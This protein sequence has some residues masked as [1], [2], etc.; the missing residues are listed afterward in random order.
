MMQNCIGAHM[1]SPNGEKF[2]ISMRNKKNY[3]V[4]DI[5]VQHGEIIEIKGRQNQPPVPKYQLPIIEWLKG[6]DLT[7]QLCHDVVRIIEEVAPKIINKLASRIN[8]TTTHQAKWAS[9]FSTSTADF[10]VTK[11]LTDNPNNIN[12][13]SLTNTSEHLMADILDRMKSNKIVLYNKILMKYSKDED[14]NGQLQ[15][16]LFRAAGD[17]LACLSVYNSVFNPQEA[18]DSILPIPPSE[19]PFLFERFRGIFDN[20]DVKDIR[21][22]PYAERML[23]ANDDAL[24]KVS[25][26]PYAKVSAWQKSTRK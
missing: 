16:R 23:I 14:K 17:D 3:P 2:I 8:W 12:D 20:L 13:I 15:Q 10:I 18:V 24:L 21:L 11:L 7:I 22:V 26:K 6:T 9:F 4:A 5:R 19:F 25:L 1:I